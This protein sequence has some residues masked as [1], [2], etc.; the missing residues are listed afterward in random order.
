MH[1]D[2]IESSTYGENTH[3]TTTPHDTPSKE[4]HNMLYCFI[5]II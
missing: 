5:T 2:G 1:R 4:M 3:I